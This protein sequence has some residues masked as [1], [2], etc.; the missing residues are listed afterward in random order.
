MSDLLLRLDHERHER[1]ESKTRK[2]LE[3]ENRF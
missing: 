1:G 3:K 2:R